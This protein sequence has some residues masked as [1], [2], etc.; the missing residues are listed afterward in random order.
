MSMIKL[1]PVGSTP[2]S[3]PKLIIHSSQDHS[4]DPLLKHLVESHPLNSSIR[5]LLPCPAST[6][7]TTTTT[8]TQD[9]DQW[10]LDSRLPG[11]I[12]YYCSSLPLLFLIS[13]EFIEKHVRTGSTLAQSTHAMAELED[14]VSL[15]H[16]GLLVLSLTKD[17]Y[18]SAGL[19]GL[20]CK[21]DASESRH[22]VTIDLLHKNFTA[23]NKLYDRV[24]WSFT[25]VITVKFDFV[26]A[27]IADASLD[28]MISLGDI[29]CRPI[30]FPED[31]AP[32]LIKSVR[33]VSHMNN[34]FIP[35][36]SAGLINGFKSSHDDTSR[37]AIELLEWIGMACI[38][39]PRLNALDTLDPFIAQ[40]RLYEPALVGSV[41]SICWSG[42]IPP[43]F[44]HSIIASARSIITDT[45]SSSTDALNTWAALCVSGYAGSPTAWSKTPKA[46][47]STGS[48]DYAAVVTPPNSAMPTSLSFTF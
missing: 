22:V 36:L 25:H 30:E 19:T 1:I 39:S 41:A 18:E 5:L 6:T 29:T 23:G 40:V 27:S 17:T 21:A 3:V 33:T 16:P 10:D 37:C 20:S 31:A 15:V 8:T 4:K 9:H 44:I 35:N 42:F 45:P 34:V 24:T 12:S 48:I 43:V 2:V 26:M 46:C 38:E 32:V 7:T 11:C 28:P 47:I 13:P 14:T